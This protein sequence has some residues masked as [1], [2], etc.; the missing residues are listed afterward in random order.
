MNAMT[1]LVTVAFSLYL[2]IVVLRIWL[3]LARADFY[4]PV[5]QFIVKATQPILAP[6]RRVIPSMGSLDTASLV[7]ALIVA[8]GKWVVLMLMQQSAIDWA[9]VSMLAVLGVIKEAGT[10][11]FWMLLIRAILSWV[12]QGQNPFEY[13]LAQ[14]TEPFMAPIRRI[15]PPMGGLDLSLLIVM[16]ALNFTNIL[17]HDLIGPLWRLA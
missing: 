11:L 12:S 4:H 6:M 15:I 9:G 7:L 14:L 16:V 2:M 13:L 3:Q 1:Y 8:G 10:L 5:S 17:M